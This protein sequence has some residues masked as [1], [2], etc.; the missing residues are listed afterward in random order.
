MRDETRLESRERMKNMSVKDN[1]KDTGKGLGK[2]F[3][4]LGKS[5]VQSVKVGK[6]KVLDKDTEDRPDLRESWKEVGESFGQAGKSFGKAMA[7][8]A[9]KVENKL[10]EAAADEPVAEAE[11][12]KE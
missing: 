10:D 9:K 8:T 11:E 5:I 6:D 7:G 2:S 4:G 12:V 1:W 3:A